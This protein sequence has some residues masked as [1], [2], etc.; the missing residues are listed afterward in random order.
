LQRSSLRESLEWDGWPLAALVLLVFAYVACSQSI[1]NDGDAYWPVGT[2]RWILDHWS[3]PVADPFSFTARGN[4]W[5]SHEWLSEILMAV[6][7]G[8]GSWAGIGILFGAAVAA[9]LLLVGLELKRFMRP[10]HAVA[11]VVLL[12]ILLQPSLLARPHVLAWPM[13]TAWT[14]VLLRARAAHR[15]PPLA[16]VLLML[17]WAN[18]HASFAIGLVMVLFFA[19][20]ALI[21]EGD[22]KQ[23]IVRWGAFGLVSLLVTL[24]N[25]SGLQGLLYAFQV[26]AMKTLPLISEWRSSS[27]SKDPL[28]FGM[29]ALATLAVLLRRPRI[30]FPRLLLI[31]ALFYLA[32]A[33][34]R[35]QALFAIISLLL[36]APAFGK[37]GTRERET[38][39]EKSA[40]RA[41]A[42]I[43][44]LFVISAL[45]LAIAI[46]HKD[47]P[48]F[49]GRAIASVPEALRS[50]PVLN[51][52]DF[53]GA[54]IFNGIAP[55]IDGRADMYGDAHTANAYAIER[56]DARRFASAVDKWN[57]RWAILHPTERLVAV[58]DRSPGWQRIYADK[59]AAI[60]TRR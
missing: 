32:L 4:A 49:P 3:I 28:F 14:L 7:F 38:G 13:V 48:V 44:A 33:H 50:Q 34:A 42:I 52:Y 20:E 36:V 27:L 31:A 59:Y 1:F 29:T 37:D 60:Y 40:Y 53:G 43:A 16:A 5:T 55:F 51:A 17:V 46:P 2:G 9:T 35:H 30:P 21:E 25:P 19:L 39:S 12:F 18:V 41:V 22:R 57:I 6:A 24:A 10:L 23:V 58:L 56:G 54:L 45:R 47:S 8:A 15:A 26:S 11:A